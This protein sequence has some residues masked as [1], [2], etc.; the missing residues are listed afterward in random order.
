LLDGLLQLA[1]YCAFVRLPLPAGE[2][3]S[4][5]SQCQAESLHL[6]S[7]GATLHLL[8]GTLVRVAL[9]NGVRGDITQG[10][11]DEFAGT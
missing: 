5:V 8:D 3:R 6:D 11:Y 10:D 9:T 1:L 7:L 4:I 2:I